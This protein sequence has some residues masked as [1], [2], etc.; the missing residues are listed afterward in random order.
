MARD[1]FHDAVRNALVR[2]G[3][4]ITNDPYTFESPDFPLQIDLGAERLIAA[5]RENEQIAVEVKS[6]ISSSAISEFHTALG[7]Y[8]NYRIA[9]SIKDPNRHL[10]LAVPNDAFQVFF[11]RLLPMRVVSEYKISLIVYNPEEEIIEQW[12]S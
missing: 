9:L 6:F 1:V 8:L 11:Q 5:T 3:W 10:F 4:T 7:Q 2:E 12:I